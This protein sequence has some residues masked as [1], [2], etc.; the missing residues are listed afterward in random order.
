MQAADLIL[1]EATPAEEAQLQS[2]MTRNPDVFLNTDGPTLPDVL[3]EKT[4]DQLM[5]AL[6]ARDIPPF[7]AAKFQPWYLMM[8]LAI[9]PC[10]MG[11]M[12]AGRRGL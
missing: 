6:R 8:T 12:A 10:V 3:P 7:L 5:V 11:D 9:P 2:L 4:W 1:L